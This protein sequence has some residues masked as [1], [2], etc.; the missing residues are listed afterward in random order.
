MEYRILDYNAFLRSFGVKPKCSMGFFLGAGSSIEAGI[1]S[2]N[3]LV[4]QFKRRI[5]CTQFKIKDEKFKDL[6]SERN[7]RLLQEHFDHSKD[8]PPTGHRSEYASM[9]IKVNTTIAF[10]SSLYTWLRCQKVLSS[11]K[12]LFSMSQ[13][14]CATSTNSAVE[15]CLGDIVVTHNHSLVLSSISPVFW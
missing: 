11:L 13:R 1:P 2:A 5:Y 7:R 4:W 15:R 3:S 14:W 6:E 8:Y 10:A 12:P 9:V